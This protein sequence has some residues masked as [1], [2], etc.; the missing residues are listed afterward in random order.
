M[1]DP[2]RKRR[3]IKQN[4]R[5]TQIRDRAQPVPALLTDGSITVEPPPTPV[6]EAPVTPLPTTISNQPRFVDAVE[7]ASDFR[8]ADEV[9]TSSP[10]PSSPPRRSTRLGL[11]T[12]SSTRFQDEVFYSNLQSSS[13]S[14]QNQILAY[15][16]A[17]DTDY[18]TGMYNGLDPR[19]YAAGNKLHDPDQPSLLEAIHGAEF[20]HYIEAM[21]LEIMQLLKQKTWERMNRSDVP[22]DQDG[23]EN[24]NRG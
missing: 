22:K 18:E 21:K 5:A 11:G 7:F 10:S 20:H 12:V 9:S 24:I 15:H 17:L 16:A 1:V 2:S 4:V 14:H 3:K 23:D 8:P 6:V 19:A 13:Q